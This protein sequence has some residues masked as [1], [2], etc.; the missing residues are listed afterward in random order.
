MIGMPRLPEHFTLIEGFV[1][2]DPQE[3][4]VHLNPI[5][6]VESH[7]ILLPH[8]SK[9]VNA[10]SASAETILKCTKKKRT[11]RMRKS[12]PGPGA[13]GLT[14]ET[15]ADQLL[16]NTSA[17]AASQA[18]LPVPLPVELDLNSYENLQLLAAVKTFMGIVSNHIQ[19]ILN[20][21]IQMQQQ[22]KKASQD[23]RRLLIKSG[24]LPRHALSK[25]KPAAS[26]TAPAIANASANNNTTTIT[27]ATTANVNPV[28]N[29]NM[30]VTTA[31]TATAANSTLSDIPRIESSMYISAPGSAETSS[32]SIPR[33]PSLAQQQLSPTNAPVSR[34]NSGNEHS[35]SIKSMSELNLSV[36]SDKSNFSPAAVSSTGSARRDSTLS[37][38]GLSSA[39]SRASTKP[40]P[41]PPASV[42]RHD[43]RQ[44]ELGPRSAEEPEPAARP[45]T[46][47]ATHPPSKFL[48]KA[49]GSR[50]SLPLSGPKKDLEEK[51]EH[52]PLVSPRISS[53]KTPKGRNSLSKEPSFTLGST[54]NNANT[55]AGRKLT[56]KSSDMLLGI[57]GKTNTKK[58]A[59]DNKVKAPLSAKGVPL[60]PHGSFHNVP[61]AT[62]SDSTQH[63][64]AA[65][66]KTLVEP[67]VSTKGG[68]NADEKGPLSLD[69]P[70]NKDVPTPPQTTHIHRHNSSNALVFTLDSLMSPMVYPAQKKSSFLADNTETTT[71]GL[72][73]TVPATV[74]AAVP[75]T[76]AV[77]PTSALTD[78]RNFTS[79]ASPTFDNLP[80]KA[81]LYADDEPRDSLNDETCSEITVTDAGGHHG[82]GEEESSLMGRVQETSSNDSGD[83]LSDI[84][85]SVCSDASSLPSLKSVSL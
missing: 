35:V 85:E 41:K 28:S 70:D 38:R 79:A 43:R 21:A 57:A 75:A 68:E 67:G 16:Q 6:V 13:E 62:Q 58:T 34:A 3:R 69:V 4:I 22:S 73:P 8:G 42:K 72:P 11:T 32:N 25:K 76:V 48:R 39:K 44:S 19:A 7:T 17:N 80:S 59:E 46:T 84:N 49:S 30:S 50:H 20:T 29:N 14:G 66:L 53:V 33:P 64:S 82:R 65:D 45:F 47:A 52:T 60:D 78:G 5:D 56:T 36:P 71:A 1:V 27:S 24:S 18:P 61:S 77:I 9:L 51:D 81:D 55:P 2:I 54:G 40:S 15:L 83:K 74:P 12:T 63:Q 37:P 10:L 23:Q 26:T 31:T